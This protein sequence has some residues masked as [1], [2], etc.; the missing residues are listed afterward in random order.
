MPKDI[1]DPLNAELLAG[2]ARKRIRQVELAAE[3]GMSQGS[4][5]DRLN[6]RTQWRLDELRQAAEYV[7]IPM[8]D[9]VGAA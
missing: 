3:L 1:A 5:S 9:L 6:S 8:T 7:G 4:L 2:M